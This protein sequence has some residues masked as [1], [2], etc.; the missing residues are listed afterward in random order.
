VPP[1]TTILRKLL[2]E[3][4]TGKD[5]LRLFV[6]DSYADLDPV[7]DWDAGFELVADEVSRTLKARGELDGS[8][9]DALIEARS[10]QDARI[11]TARREAGLGDG[12]RAAVPPSLPAGPQPPQVG[13]TWWTAANIPWHRPEP[14]QALQL[15]AAGYGD[16]R[17]IT[18][19]GETA[20]IHGYD[21]D[22]SGSARQVW[23]ALLQQAARGHKTADLLERVL[24][25]ETRKAI[26]RDL[27]PLLGDY[28][29]A[30]DAAMVGRSGPEAMRVRDGSALV[31]LAGTLEPTSDQ[32]IEGLQGIVDA[33]NGLGDP[34]AYIAGIVDA[35]RRTA[36]IE[37]GGRPIGTGF[38]VGA[39]YL[40]TNAHVVGASDGP[41]PADLGLV[42]WFD[43]YSGGLAAYAER[44][45]RVRGKVVAYS[46]P[47]AAEALGAGSDWNASRDHLDYALVQ[48]D[49]PVGTQPGGP[50]ELA[51]GG[52][53]TARGHYTPST[54][55]Y[56]FNRTGMLV[57]VQHPLGEHQVMSK[58][59]PA[60]ELNPNGT[61]VRYSAN[62]LQ[63]SSGSAVVDDRGRLVALHHYGAK[64]A[65]QGVP[66]SM[67][68]F[69][70]QAEHPALVSEV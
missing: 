62:T 38:L 67:V 24:S 32:P 69:A 65:N 29:P 37:V 39:D 41:P 13:E 64:G 9:F 63:G 20:G 60:F 70:L 68:A 66:I 46:P 30:V 61:R 10:G 4:F 58:A 6:G 17:D 31:S 14:Q 57:I 12:A 23:I 15:L 51:I 48:L 50:A 33:G 3:I 53:G 49:E 25:D 18:F 22:T 54:V 28:T 34:L 27:E 45:R 59:T 43:F 42:A 11:R 44:G 47:T 36:L 2:L 35:M 5:E 55:V 56:D 8:L 1:P 26:W 21:Y 16:V 7:V 52:D 40:L 19:L